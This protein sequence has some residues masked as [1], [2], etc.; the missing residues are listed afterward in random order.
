M[1]EGLETK[2]LKNIEVLDGRSLRCPERVLDHSHREGGKDK[3]ELQLS[4]RHRDLPT[5]DSGSKSR[6]PPARTRS[7]ST[8]EGTERVPSAGRSKD[9]PCCF[10]FICTSRPIP[11]THWKW[12]G[13]AQMTSREPARHKLS[14]V[15]LLAIGRGSYSKTYERTR[16]AVVV[17]SQLPAVESDLQLNRIYLC[18]FATAS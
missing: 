18:C 4:R 7:Q 10:L 6:V 15:A 5:F 12:T 3:E 11:P 16:V 2:A 1:L 9:M 14:D 13:V 8:A 17:A